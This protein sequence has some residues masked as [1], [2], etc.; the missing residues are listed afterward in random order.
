MKL[1]GYLYDWPSECGH[2]KVQGLITFDLLDNPGVEREV[3]REDCPSSF[4]PSPNPLGSPG[5]A[6]NKS[7]SCVSPQLNNA[8]TTKP[9]I[10]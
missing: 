8:E 10:R 1:T 7:D 9:S 6:T 5:L 3:V 2:L 4:V